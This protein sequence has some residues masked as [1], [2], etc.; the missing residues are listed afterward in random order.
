VSIRAVL[1]LLAAFIAVPA[2]YAGASEATRDELNR[3]RDQISRITATLNKEKDELNSLHGDLAKVEKVMG[4]LNSS[5]RDTQTDIR[6]RTST[7]RDSETEIGH[8]DTEIKTR[9]KQLKNIIR[10]SYVSG[11]A[12]YLKLLLNQENP[13]DVGRFLTYYRYLSRHRVADIV[14]FENTLERLRQVKSVLATEQKELK[15]LQKAQLSQRKNL[16]DAHAE[17]ATLVAALEQSI[18]SRQ[19]RLV[20]MQRDEKRL[21]HLLQNIG[22]AAS[23]APVDA[24]T[25]SR[26]GQMRGRLSLPLRGSISA[27]FGQTRWGTNIPLQG[28]VMDAAEGTEV[29][30]VYSGHVVFADWLRGFG[31]LLILDH[32]DGFMTLYSHNQLLFRQVGDQIEMGEAIALVGSSGGQANAG[33]Y[34]EVRKNGE[35]LNPLIWCKVE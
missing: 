14:E 18:G 1:L 3:V 32:G 30:A 17:R 25:G 13:A 28:I 35:P 11:R 10:A 29:S 34:F 20:R 22:R 19:Q 16:T 27:H 4:M 7:I 33:L 5:I 15:S 26:F 12:E 24:D 21:G 31:L 6:S 23:A 8:I 2:H 9:R